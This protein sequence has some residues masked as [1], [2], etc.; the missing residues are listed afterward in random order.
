LAETLIINWGNDEKT[1]RA[2]MD[3]V[4]ATAV[5]MMQA[6]HALEEEQDHFNLQR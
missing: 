5:H 6:I 3:V 1:L 2:E 4:S